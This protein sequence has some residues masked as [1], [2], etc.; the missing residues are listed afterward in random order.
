M[1]EPAAK[2]APQVA[3][4]LYELVVAYVKQETTVPFKQLGR[5]VVFGI[6][7][8]LLIGFGAVFLAVAGLRALQNETSG[9][10]A[11]DWNWVPYGIVTLA[12]LVGGAL[13]WKVGTR[14]RKE[15]A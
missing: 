11:N 12:L 6:L 13:T 4:E 5:Y 7:G 1:P 14:R 15:R 3:T 9:T 8:S 10:F 2:S